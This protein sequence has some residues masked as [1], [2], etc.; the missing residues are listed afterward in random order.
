MSKCQTGRKKKKENE[1]RK[2]EKKSLKNGILLIGW[3]WKLQV[4]L[5]ANPQSFKK[6]YFCK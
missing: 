4:I 1:K 6:L 5:T 3:T 2:K